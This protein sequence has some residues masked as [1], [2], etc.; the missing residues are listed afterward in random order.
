MLTELK[1]KSIYDS[2]EHDLVEDLFI[3]LLKKSVRYDRGVGFFTSGWLRQAAKGLIEIGKNSGKIR[4]VISPIISKEDWE[5]MKKGNDAKRNRIIY[6]AL[7]DSIE[8][9]EKTLEKHPLNA[10]AWLIA[11]NI[12]TIKF[13]VPKGKLQGGDFH[14]KFGIFEDQAGNRV[15]IHGS[16]NDTIH[17]SL[18]GEAFSVFKSWEQ[19]Q[20]D[21]VK[22]HDQRFASL[23]GDKNPMFEIYEI[24]D[25][26]KTKIIRLRN[27]DRPYK[28]D[29]TEKITEGAEATV[30]TKKIILRNYQNE[31]LNNWIK[32]DHQGIFEMATGTGKTITSLACAESIYKKEKRIALIVCVPYLHLIDQWKEEMKKF[33]FK[34][35]LCS[36]K[37]P[38]WSNK[39]QLRIQDYNLKFKN[40]ISCIITHASA[41]S[42]NFQD[43]IDQI[44]TNPKMAIYDEVHS[45]GSSKLK[46]ALSRNIKFR[47]GL[48]A[49]PQRW[50]DA[51][52]TNVIMKYFKGVCF[53]YPLE[54]AI[55]E[56]LSEYRYIPHVVEL[57]NEEFYE[58]S[59]LSAQIG[60]IY[61]SDECP[62]DNS[63]LNTL[64]RERKRLINNATQKNIFLKS[65]I[66][67]QLKLFKDENKVFSHALFYCP[68]GG[69]LKVL[70]LLANMG[71]K[72]REFIYKVD[73]N[74]RKLILKQ[75]S[76]G[77]IQA[78]VAIKCLDEGVD[79]PSTKYA[80]VLASTSNPREFIQR[81]GRILRKHK[82]KKEAIIHDFIVFPP[83]DNQNYQDMNEEYKL[84]IIKRE[85]PRFAE[86]ASAAINEFEARNSVRKILGEFN[87]EYLLDMKPWDIYSQNTADNLDL[88]ELEEE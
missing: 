85:M 48:S 63:Y 45:L 29:E 24:P 68:V 40:K 57:N 52:G 61:H 42:R 28:S 75:F 84:S 37:Y 53:S 25:A 82:E 55:G 46:N 78:I 26:V 59:K 41:A 87:A 23:F 60:K 44:N 72:A 22:I 7:M 32:S 4:M 65:L 81:R 11:D 58:Y 3:P 88:N 86:F 56:H 5:Y 15:A 20:L 10:L 79:V 17:G 50:F 47:I 67:K 39:L 19:G 51:F 30:I 1:L 74:E 62:E 54:E 31:A 76:D 70:K 14:D 6:E 12:L 36:S 2:S 18:N 71:I 83:L 69:H 9:F 34:P 77:D 33:G 27:Y 49:T 8:T 35:I 38:N 73:L 80:F 16:Y 64:L 21:Y 43:L 13:A 66:Q